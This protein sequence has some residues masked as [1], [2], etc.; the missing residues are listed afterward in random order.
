LFVLL[1]LK[2]TSSSSSGNFE[3][4]LLPQ[5]MIINFPNQVT[6][7]EITACVL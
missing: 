1:Y 4:L 2:A 5:D 3:L 7:G 6:G